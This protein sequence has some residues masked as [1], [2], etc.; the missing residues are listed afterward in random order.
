MGAMSS[1]LI[2]KIPKKAEKVHGTLAYFNYMTALASFAISPHA[3]GK[4]AHPPCPPKTGL[5]VHPPST[6]CFYSCAADLC[7]ARKG[8]GHQ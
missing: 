3:G 4:L 7:G 6:P 2:M 1:L 5:H 8:D